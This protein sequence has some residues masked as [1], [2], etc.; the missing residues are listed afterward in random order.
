[1]FERYIALFLKNDQIYRIP[2]CS[3]AYG[4]ISWSLFHLKNRQKMLLYVIFLP[5]FKLVSVCTFNLYTLQSSIY[6][7]K[8][9]ACL[10]T[11][12]P[13]VTAGLII[14]KLIINKEIRTNLLGCISVACDT[15]HYG[16][17]V[18]VC[19]PCPWHIV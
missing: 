5:V 3:I 6:T 15:A 17:L 16:G 18:I 19:V 12:P 2:R 10:C 11:Q 4:E 14:N 8:I 9:I 1:M 13:C 7:D